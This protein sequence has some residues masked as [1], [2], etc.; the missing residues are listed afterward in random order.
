MATKGYALTDSVTGAVPVAQGGTGASTA[1]DVRTNLGLGS[2]AT[3]ASSSVSITGGTISST[4]V[5]GTNQYALGLVRANSQYASIADGSETGLDFNG[6]FTVEA[7]IN[8]FTTPAST[9]QWGVLSR[10]SG[11][12]TTTKAWATMVENNGGTVG[13]RC[14][15]TPDGTSSDTLRV[16]MELSPGSWIHIAFVYVIAD[17]KLYGYCNG[18]LIGS[19]SAGAQSSIQASVGPCYLGSKYDATHFFNG[20]LGYVRAWN[21][22]RTQAQLAA[23]MNVQLTTATNLVGNWKL[24]NDYTDASG[25][26]NNMSATGSPVFTRS[27]PFLG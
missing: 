5:T 22:A 26:S 6:D 24:Q 20:L 21:V 18:V 19:S 3:Q 10:W 4:T 27:V 2:L 15:I 9:A 12:G 14:D 7:Y 8:M 16:P 1:L 17:K 13:L 25:N 23:N 11:S